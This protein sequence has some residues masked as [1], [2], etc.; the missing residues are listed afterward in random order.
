MTEVPGESFRGEGLAA[1]NND[2]LLVIPYS[3][4]LFNED[5]AE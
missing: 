4:E 5:N 3:F 2:D 1:Y